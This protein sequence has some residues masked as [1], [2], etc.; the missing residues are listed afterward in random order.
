MPK[1][2]V[3]VLHG[4]NLNL[5]GQREPEIYGHTTLEQINQALLKRSAQANLSLDCFQSNCEGEL[6]TKAQSALKDYD[7]IIINPAALTHTSV[8][9]RDA[10][11]VCGKPCIEVHISNIYKREEF[12][13]FSFF[14]DIALGVISGFGA[15]SYN[16]ALEY[17]INTYLEGN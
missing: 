7:F 2:R 13:H 3:L 14:S 9:L 16:L 4:P 1:F 10:I 5:L 17:I 6:I 11:L 8:A 12:R 15:H